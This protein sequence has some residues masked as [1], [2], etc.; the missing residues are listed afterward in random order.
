MYKSVVYILGS[1]QKMFA[2]TTTQHMATE[3]FTGT[4]V[5]L[6]L[7]NELLDLICLYGDRDPLREDS[8]EQRTDEVVINSANN[9]FIHRRIHTV[10]S[11][12][13]CLSFDF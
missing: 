10:S 8:P 12:Y 4:P 1:E 2:K 13:I 9:V 7:T 5:S 6:D 11:L 3:L